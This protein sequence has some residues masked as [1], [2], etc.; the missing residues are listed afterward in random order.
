[1]N[2]NLKNKIETCLLFKYYFRFSIEIYS[3]PKWKTKL[4]LD[5]LFCFLSLSSYPLYYLIV[6]KKQSYFQKINL[7]MLACFSFLNSS[8]KKKINFVWYFYTFQLNHSCSKIRTKISTWNQNE[9]YRLKN[10][11]IQLISI[12]LRVQQ[13]ECLPLWAE[14]AFPSP[15]TFGTLRLPIVK[16]PD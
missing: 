3:L 14:L 10:L 16:S 5:T 13:R 12:T 15:A 2:L 11:N 4:L 8:Q 7:C 6:P 1:M 9:Q